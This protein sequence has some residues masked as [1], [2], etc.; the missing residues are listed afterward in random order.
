MDHY[1]NIYAILEGEQHSKDI[2]NRL[3]NLLV[4]KN[5]LID[6]LNLDVGMSCELEN[7]KNSDFSLRTDG[8]EI[9]R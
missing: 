8:S 5:A 4:H 9:M 3:N 7:G 6:L 2:D 1:Q